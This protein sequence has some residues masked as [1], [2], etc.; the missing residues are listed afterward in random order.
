MALVAG[1]VGHIKLYADWKNLSTK[2][3]RIEIDSVLA[4]IKPVEKFEASDNSEF[5]RGLLAADEMKWKAAGAGTADKNDEK[6]QSLF[7]QK[8]IDNIQISLSNVHIRYEDGISAQTSTVHDPAR[9]FALGLTIDRLSIT[10]WTKENDGT[11]S[12][13]FVEEP[14][15][16]MT[17]RIQL[18]DSNGGFAVYCNSGPEPWTNGGGQPISPGEFTVAMK[19]LI[20]A[21]KFTQVGPV[22][23]VIR[24]IQLAIVLLRDKS[25]GKAYRAEDGRASGDG[26]RVISATQKEAPDTLVRGPFRDGMFRYEPLNDITVDMEEVSIVLA[27]QTVTKFAT[28]GSWMALVSRKQVYEAWKPSTRIGLQPGSSWADTREWWIFAKKCNDHANKLLSIKWDAKNILNSCEKRRIYLSLYSR[29][30]AQSQGYEW[31]VS[32]TDSEQEQLKRLED[33][34]DVSVTKTWRRLALRRMNEE[35]RRHAASQPVKRSW[36]GSSK[37]SYKG[38]T[39]QE[40]QFLSSFDTD[41]GE[42][43]VYPED[44]IESKIALTLKNATLTLEKDEQELA[45]VDLAG[46]NVK[47]EMRTDG[48]LTAKIGL[49]SFV[50]SDRCS[51]GDNR[52]SFR[53]VIERDRSRQHEGQLLE[54]AFEKKPLAHP[55]VDMRVQL[56]LQPLQIVFNPYFVEQLVAYSK[57]GEELALEASL[58]DGIQDSARARAMKLKRQTEILKETALT[59]RTIMDVDVALSAPTILVPADCSADETDCIMISLGD[60]TVKSTKGTHEHDVFALGLHDMKIQM[61]TTDGAEPTG[62][63]PT[64][65]VQPVNMDLELCNSVRPTDP[66][67]PKLKMKGRLQPVQLAV[68]DKLITRLLAL[69]TAIERKRTAAIN[70]VRGRSSSSTQM[71]SPK[72]KSL[73]KS[74]AL[75]SSNKSI[76]ASTL[77]I[78]KKTPSKSMRKLL[79]KA[80]AQHKEEANDELAQRLPLW[81]QL[82]A[83]FSLEEIRLAI[84]DQSGSR[85]LAVLKVQGLRVA[86]TMRPYDKHV[87]L[88]LRNFQ[89]DDSYRAACLKMP[90]QLLSSSKFGS[91]AAVNLLDVDFWDT[92]PHSPENW[93]GTSC[94]PADCVG[95]KLNADFGF[96]SLNLHLGTLSKLIDL[97]KVAGGASETPAMHTAPSASDTASEAV[98]QMAA[99]SPARATLEGSFRGG[100]LCVELIPETARRQPTAIATLQLQRVT[101]DLTINEIGVIDVGFMLANIEVLRG[102]PGS[103]R[104]GGDYVVTGR[105]HATAKDDE[106]LAQTADASG[107]A[108]T[109]QRLPVTQYK[110]LLDIKAVLQPES[111]PDETSVVDASFSGLNIQVAGP[112]VKSILQWIGD[113]P[114]GKEETVKAKQAAAKAQQEAAAKAR[115]G[116]AAA[117]SKLMKV[118][119]H[120]DA[121]T[122]SIPLIENSDQ[123]EAD[124][125]LQFELGGIDVKVRDQVQIV[126]FR[127]TWATLKHGIRKQQL[128]KPIRGMVQV[129]DRQLRDG[130]TSQTGRAQS[131]K[132]ITLTGLSTFESHVS[133]RD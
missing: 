13:R 31:A 68:S 47:A 63:P 82:V 45:V 131:L 74:P 100:G 114:I 87:V 107:D 49:A 81:K 90:C 123:V 38:L 1:A 88:G 20:K 15:Q 92:E 12:D 4:I 61:F 43:Q 59:V 104:T 51:T 60:L 115:Q 77:S 128:L 119:V 75:E 64:E 132:T 58:A 26:W 37:T 3:I 94:V 18:G 99:G 28:L 124:H 29:K 97:S 72:L 93:R 70:S 116:A 11:W 71:T 125:C 96:L 103:H 34:F 54:C 112:F 108:A 62:A 109:V 30:S 9:C 69:G 7:V 78:K 66:S 8:I 89:I 17:K 84:S 19:K 110:D 91:E 2:A 113:N 41:E 118:D 117:K 73:P 44:W 25:E 98:V 40:L 33:E 24:P 83:E 133:F 14:M 79:S 53:H 5:K 50:V 76:M 67:V 32:L 129:A 130:L 106:Q 52:T 55:G 46:I 127:D 48:G 86:A 23:H 65:I 101:A 56:A 102:S 27:S 22:D 57:T 80:H 122:L 6:A 35:A 16:M 10:S 105:E 85:E 121:V 39:E 21:K 95:R 120:L 42:K 36:F 111:R 126:E